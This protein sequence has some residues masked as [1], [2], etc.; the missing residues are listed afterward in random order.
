MLDYKMKEL[1]VSTPHIGRGFKQ[2]LSQILLNP[3]LDDLW[4][5]WSCD[6]RC[7]EC[8][9]IFGEFGTLKYILKLFIV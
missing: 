6:L 9:E 8:G 5:C 7:C 3:F 4:L 2:I 1:G